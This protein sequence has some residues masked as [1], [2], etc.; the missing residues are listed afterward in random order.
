[1]KL[2][3][4]RELAM[5]ELEVEV[6]LALLKGQNATSSEIMEQLNLTNEE[7]IKIAKDLESKGMIIELHMN[8][9]RALHPRFAIVNRYRKM[10]VSNKIEFKKNPRIDQLAVQVEKYQESTE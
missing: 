9:F 5:E 2:L 1:M 3:L 7:F 6:F 8:E 4:R 10:C